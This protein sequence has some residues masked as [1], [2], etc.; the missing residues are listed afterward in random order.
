MILQA[1]MLNLLLTAA[2]PAEIQV[3]SFP[4][5]GKVALSLGVKGKAD[6]ERLGTVTKVSFQFEGLAAPHAALAGMNAFVAWVVSPEGSFENLGELEIDGSKASLEATTRFDRFGILITVEPHY[7]VDRPGSAIVFQN[8]RPRSVRS[9]PLAIQVGEYEYRN[10]PPAILNVPALVLQA[11]AAMAI[12]QSA[13]A[14]RLAE[15]EFRQARV[16][17]DT[18]EDLVRR[19]SPFDVIAPSA[20]E[21]I[22]RAQRAFTMSRQSVR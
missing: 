3:V 14:E 18:M 9:V 15:A 11:R 16:S 8:D 4:T 1:L 21:A 22:R 20:H 7:M 6:V 5:K 17:L 2:T 19:A 13:Q 12:A 10:L